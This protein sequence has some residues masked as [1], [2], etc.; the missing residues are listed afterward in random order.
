MSGGNHPS[1]HL[2]AEV[3]KR[4]TRAF[5]RT[6]LWHALFDLAPDGVYRATVV[7]HGTGGLLHHLFT[8]TQLC[9]RFVFC[10]TG[11]QVALSGCY[12]PS[13]AVEPGLSSRRT[14]RSVARLPG[15][16]ASALYFTTCWLEWLY[17]DFVA[18]V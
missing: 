11:L 16:P 9:G 15:S 2:I 18:S 17:E 6:T 1:R 5:G 7:A 3:L 14:L 10:G 8:L 13:C 12:P 4:P